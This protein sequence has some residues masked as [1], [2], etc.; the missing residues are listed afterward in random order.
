MITLTTLQKYFNDF[1]FYDKKLDVEKIDP[2]M[3]N[4]LMIKGREEI[5]KIGFGVS[6]SLSLFEHAKN[7]GYDALVVHHSF[8]MPLFNRYDEI[9]QKRM[10]FLTKNDI[11]LFG[12]HFLLDSHPEVGNNR[13]ILDVIGANPA[14]PY[15]LHSEPW[16][17][18]GE[19]EKEMDFSKILDLFGSLM[20]ERAKVYDFGLQKIK[21]V[22]VCSGKG[23]PSASNMQELIDKKIDLFITGEVHEWNRELFREAKLNFIAAGHYATEV[24]GIKALMEKVSENFPDTDCEWIDLVNDI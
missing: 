14:K 22:V 8:N 23:A 20:S 5:K 9:F 13:K 16:G 21:K 6:A 11:S 3:T 15:Y 24:F 10:Q 7:A 2:Y 18:F 4:G 1:M 17:W 19:Y 12:F